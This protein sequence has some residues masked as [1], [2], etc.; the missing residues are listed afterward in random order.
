MTSDFSKDLRIFDNK[1]Y[2]Y[3]VLAGSFIMF[4][5]SA[6]QF[7]CTNYLIQALHT[8]QNMAFIYFGAVAITGPIVGAI[9]SA[10]IT[11]RLGGYHSKKTLTFAFLVGLSIAIS[12]LIIL[13]VQNIQTAIPLFW[14]CICNGALLFPIVIGIMLTK[15]R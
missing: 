5:S 11:D 3:L 9:L 10:I 12:S 15:V 2:I 8:P 1:A 6:M 13:L 7:W 14:I 4:A